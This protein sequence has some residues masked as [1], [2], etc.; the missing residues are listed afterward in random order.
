MTQEN[1]TTV[2]HL[3]CLILPDDL[4]AIQR[5]HVCVWIYYN[6]TLFIIYIY[7]Y[8]FVL[9]YIMFYYIVSYHIILFSIN[10]NI[11]LFCS[12]IWFY[13]NILYFVL[14]FSYNICSIWQVII[15]IMYMIYSIY[16]IQLYIVHDNTDRPSYISGMFLPGRGG[17][18]RLRRWGGEEGQV[19]LGLRLTGEWKIR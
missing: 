12:M 7:I 6:I 9:Y 15:Y 10:N 14:L 13:Y 2:K 3:Y 19:C 1:H 16:S 18:G 4:L 17:D 8:H 5:V 11:I